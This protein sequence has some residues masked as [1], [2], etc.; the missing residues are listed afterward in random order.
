[1]KGLGLLTNALCICTVST[2]LVSCG[3]NSEMLPQGNGADASAVFHA[4]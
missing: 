2:I 1:M 4:S 3:A